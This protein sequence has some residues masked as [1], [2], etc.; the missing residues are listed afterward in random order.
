[1]PAAH[2]LEYYNGKLLN[3]FCYAKISCICDGKLTNIFL[4][5]Y[6]GK[7]HRTRIL[8]P[9]ASFSFYTRGGYSKAM[10]NAFIALNWGIGTEPAIVSEIND[11]SGVSEAIQVPGMY[12]IVAKVS[13]QSRGEIAKSVKNIRAIAN[14]RSD[15]T[16]IMSEENML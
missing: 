2:L 14:I 8:S 1:M 7:A 3:Y 12:D 4:S 13:E 11:M 16:M 5:L 6:I 15:P 10:L 9:S